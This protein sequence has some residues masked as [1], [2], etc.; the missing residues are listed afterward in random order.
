MVCSDI[1][2]LKEQKIKLHETNLRLDAALEHMLQG[3]C[4]YD[5]EG[6]LQVVNRRFCE[7]FAIPH[8]KIR[9]GMSFSDVLALSIAA[10]NHG[11]PDGG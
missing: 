10:G 4:L 6:R 2:A 1:S 8:G 9:P 11:E 5:S 7:I 3:L